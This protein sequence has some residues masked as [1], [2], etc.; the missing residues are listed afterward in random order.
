MSAQERAETLLRRHQDVSLCAACIGHQL[1]IAAVAA[2]SILWVLQKRPGYEMRAA[3]CAGCLR[4]KRTVR[5]VGGGTPLGV[6]TPI[7][8]FLLDNPGIT[9]CSACLAL[10]A[11]SSLV[12]VRRIIPLLAP[13]PEFEVRSGPC[14]V[15]ARGGL[16]TVAFRASGGDADAILTPT[17]E[18]HS[19]RIDVL[20]YRTA[21]GWRPYVSLKAARGPDV[22]PVGEPPSLLPTLY[23]AKPDADAA[24]LRAAETWLEHHG[25]LAD[26]DSATRR[27]R[28]EPRALTRRHCDLR[29]VLVLVIDDHRDTRDMF[30]EGLSAVGAEVLSAASGSDALR[31]AEKSLPTVVVVDIAMP[32]HDG[33]WFVAELRNLTGGDAIP[34]I[35]VTGTPL[36]LLPQS[37]KDVGFVRAL[38][39]PVDPLVLA[40]IVADVV[41]EAIL[42]RAINSR[43]T[44]GR[45]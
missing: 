45:G 37:A 40:D 39:K 35:A 33:F 5:Y 42:T 43:R 34:A 29:G 1:R 8:D 10:A 15:C 20:S 19:V 21:R 18:R 28:P 44:R 41:E 25:I 7:V 9:L 12:D 16:V 27:E 6:A 31:L 36:D 3:K 30:S 17:R 13:L 11:A 38:L 24:A 26:D 23:P 22:G 4:G 2:R 14:V 32:E